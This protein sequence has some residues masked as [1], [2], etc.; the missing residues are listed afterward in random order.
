MDRGVVAKEAV[1]SHWRKWT[2]SALPEVRL[3]GGGAAPSDPSV[4]RVFFCFQKLI[5][6]F[7]LQ[8]GGGG[9]AAPLAELQSRLDVLQVSAQAVEGAT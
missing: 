2:N 9:A 1:V 3:R 4:S 6:H 5:E 8:A 7:Q